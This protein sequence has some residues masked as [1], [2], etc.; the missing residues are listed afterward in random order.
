MILRRKDNILN[1][2]TVKE[3]KDYTEI[4][5]NILQGE[6]NYNRSKK[7][8]SDVFK[9]NRKDRYETI[10]FRLTIIDSY[11]STQMNKRFFGLDDLSEKL[12]D[13]TIDDD[14]LK[15]ISLNYIEGKYNGNKIED[16]FN[17]KYGIRKTGYIVGQAASLISKYLYF[18]TEYN[19]PIYDNLVKSSYKLIIKKYSQLNLI[20]MK[21]NFDFTYFE[22]LNSLNVKAEIKDFNKLDNLLWLIGKL[23]EGSLSLILSKNNYLNLLKNIHIEKGVKS[24]DVDIVIRKFIR[25]NIDNLTDIFE[26]NE[27]KFL[28][29]TYALMDVEK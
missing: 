21:C 13:I 5:F 12:T 7:I 19:F 11:Y 6:T 26:E 4:A 27:I 9:I 8:I 17:E 24:K 29:Y 25:K 14:E 18:L 22:L 20:G 16:L 10:L 23:T 15:N 1:K 28:K 3:L 2:N